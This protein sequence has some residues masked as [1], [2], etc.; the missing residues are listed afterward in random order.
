VA[1]RGLGPGQGDWRRRALDPGPWRSPR[2]NV[3]NSL[4]GASGD[5]GVACPDWARDGERN[6]ESESG[7][8]GVLP[9]DPGVVT[10][11]SGSGLILA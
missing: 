11:P 1:L 8:P 6:L 10:A 9:D 7:R 4:R 2:C 3:G 5:S